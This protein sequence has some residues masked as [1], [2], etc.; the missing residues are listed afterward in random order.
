MEADVQMIR[1]NRKREVILPRNE[2]GEGMNLS[3]M[4]LSP[5]ADSGNESDKDSDCSGESN[6]NEVD[7]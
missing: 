6:D 1:P 3:E 7:E 2:L 5:N 4:A